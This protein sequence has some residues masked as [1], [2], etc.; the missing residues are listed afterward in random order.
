[1]DDEIIEKLKEEYEKHDMEWKGE[2][3]EWTE[4]DQKIWKILDFD[5]SDIPRIVEMR[6]SIRET[7]HPTK[8]G[9]YYQVSSDESATKG[10]LTIFNIESKQE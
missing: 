2:D 3:K 5:T 7:E 10:G 4:I 1:M 8:P 6:K 9:K